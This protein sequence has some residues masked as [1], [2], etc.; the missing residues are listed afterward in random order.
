MR[1]QCSAEKYKMQAPGN[2]DQPNETAEI[3]A[4]RAV[5]SYLWAE[6]YIWWVLFSGQLSQA[7]KQ[8]MAAAIQW[9]V[10]IKQTWVEY[11][12]LANTEA[13]RFC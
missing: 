5:A 13:A 10:D 3:C 9:A 6:D 8:H 7:S 1:I 2:G 12:E 4:H 11:V